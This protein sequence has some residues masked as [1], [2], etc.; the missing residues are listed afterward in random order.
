MT[1]GRRSQP[2]EYTDNAFSPSCHAFQYHLFCSWTSS[3]PILYTVERWWRIERYNGTRDARRAGARSTARAEVTIAFGSRTKYA[4][5]RL[6]NT[7]C[8]HHRSA[9]PPANTFAAHTRCTAHLHTLLHCCALHA[10]RS[11]PLPCLHAFA[12]TTHFTQHH[13]NVKFT[14]A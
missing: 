3:L 8:T 10:P 1:G 2:Y 6:P 7:H 11:A 4:Y 5:A 9:A 12:R 13:L 14:H